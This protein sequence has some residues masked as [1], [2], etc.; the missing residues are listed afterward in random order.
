MVAVLVVPWLLVGT[1]CKSG[2]PSRETEIVSF[3]I[4]PNPVVRGGSVVVAWQAENVGVFEGRPYCTL[5][6][7]FDGQPAE[8]PEVV[9]CTDLRTDE[10]DASEAGTFVNY[11]FSA[12][13]RSGQA[14]EFEDI[15][16]TILHAGVTVTPASVTLELLS[17]QDF[18]ATVT[19]TSDTR[20]TWDA[21]CGSV[22]GSG[23]TI[24][25][26]APASVPDPATCLVTATSRA[27]ASAS[28]SAVVTV[29]RPDPAD[30]PGRWD[31]AR[32]S[33]ASWGP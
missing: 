26:T 6:R 5:Q 18:T 21:S 12:L 2:R 30:Q 11:R 4:S 20:V 25:Y 17:S 16:L 19:G 22:S 9:K 32:W 10:I 15:T 27:D 8:E 31:T 7:A 3:E 29:V 24:T 33:E 28:A 14:Y 1:D 13:R 23:N